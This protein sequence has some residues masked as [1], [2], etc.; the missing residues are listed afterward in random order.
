MTGSARC[1][2]HHYHD[3][4]AEQQ[5]RER[6]RAQRQ[7]PQSPHSGEAAA[8]TAVSDSAEIGQKRVPGI[9]TD[10]APE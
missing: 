6:L 3:Q 2:A 1:R 8:E 10:D 7:Q 5:A 4:F 9:D